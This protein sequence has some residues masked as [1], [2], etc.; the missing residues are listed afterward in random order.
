MA[1]YIDIF[2]I[3][4]NDDYVKYSFCRAG[5]EITGSLVV[6]KDD[7]FI[8]PIGCLDKS[9]LFEYKRA[10]RKIFLHWQAGEYPDKTCWAT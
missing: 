8:E 2:K 10:S 6:R 9:S 1:L 7:G 3:E 4:E 5:N